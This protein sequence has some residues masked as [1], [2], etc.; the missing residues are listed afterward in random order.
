MRTELLDS[1]EDLTAWTGIASGQAKVIISQDKGPHG[2]A[3]RLDFDFKGGGGFVVARKPFSLALPESYAFNF[4]VR[5][6]APANKFEFKLVDSHGRNVWWF[7]RDRFDFPRNWRSIRI[8]SSQI[9]FAWGPLGGGAMRQAG[10]IEFVIAAGP[11]GKG[12][13]WIDDLRFEDLTPDAAPTVRASSALP[14]YGPELVLERSAETCWRSEPSHR[15][16][17]LLIDFHTEREYGGL[18]V[19]W[20]PTAPTRDFD[21][22]ISNDGIVWRTVYSAS[23]VETESS[24]VYLPGTASRY[25]RLYLG[26]ATSEVGIVHIGI[27]PYE[28]SRS[29]NAFF[30]SIAK[31]EARGLYP[32]YLSGEQTYW[33]PAGVSGETTTSGLLNEEGMIEVDKGSFSIEPFLYTDGQLITWADDSC[34]QELERGHLP[35]PSS[36]W[37]KDNLRLKTTLFAAH[38]SGMPVLLARYRIENTGQNAREVRFFAALRPFQ[39]TPPW[40]A[41]EDFGGVSP[42]RELAYVGGSVFVNRSKR[43]IPLSTPSRFGATAFAQGTLTDYLKRGDV[44]PRTT[45]IDTFGYASGAFRYDLEL[46]PGFAHEIY[47]AIPFGS[48]EAEPDGSNEMLL[49]SVS[50]ADLFDAARRDWQEKLNHLDIRLPP[51]AQHFVDTLK[52]ATAHILINR[53]GPALQ[54]GPRR[55]TRSWIRDGAIMAAALLRMGCAQEAKDFIRWYAGYQAEDG[56]VPCCVDRN[57]P[58]WL[59]EYDSQGELIYTVMECYRF[60]ND[61][62][63]LIELWPAILKSVDRIEALRSQRLTPEF[64]MPEKRVCYGLLPE[65]ASH[66]GYLAHPVHAYWDD[67]WALRGL[68]DA[69]DMAEIIDDR[70]QASRI[71][72]LRD[73][74]RETLYA[75]I[76]ATMNERDID[77]IPGSVEWADFDPTA[78]AAAIAP[79]DELHNLPEAAVTRTFEEYLAKFHERRS[80]SVDWTNYS[81]YEVRIVGALVHLGMRGS[82]HELVDFLLADRRPLPW[83]QWPEIAWRDPK[84]PGHIGDIPHSWIS[85]EYVL[86]FLSMFAFEREA[87]RSLVIAAGISEDWLID[88]FEVAVE[89]LPTHYG[90]LSYRLRLVGHDKALLD[91]S[92]TIVFPP[93]GIVIRPPLPR[94]IVY[95]EV[96]GERSESFDAETAIV[97]RLPVGIIIGF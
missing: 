40:Q 57:G 29:I 28:F 39:V 9:E 97:D 43:V 54:P 44:P 66:E 95:V 77:F 59:P 63:F 84:T 71:Q 25:L 38:L 67:F 32:K 62:E 73:S 90:K 5:G 72:A 56:N 36:V 86:S 70:D 78:T 55:Y 60:T 52:T 47:L 26:N 37:N 13:V 41:F 45:V 80:D 76:D 10:A 19:E 68:K 87:D 58:D 64:Q 11:G 15:A 42:V 83:N 50:G 12:T 35:I 17:W 20:E 74:F 23:G 89:N 31:K 4:T 75:S 94:P 61:R 7:H 24:Y 1:F 46:L 27:E 2:R 96:N 34:E 82:A 33:S 79:I 81:P 30:Q 6:A 92:G 51:K 88:G 22:Q 49:Q 21:I 91:L 14:G 16:E 3:M 93:G 53:D 8:K 48:A 85:A 69:V 65:S 18:T